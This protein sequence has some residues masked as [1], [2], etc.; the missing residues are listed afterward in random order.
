MFSFT[1]AVCSGVAGEGSLHRGI[2]SKFLDEIG[3]FQFIYGVGMTAPLCDRVCWHSCI[4]EH[5]GGED[6]DDFNGC[7]QPECAESSCYDFLLRECDPVQHAAIT[8]RYKELCTI[9]SCRCTF[10]YSPVCSNFYSRLA[11]G[12]LAGSTESAASAGAAAISTACTALAI[13][14]STATDGAVLRAL[15]RHR[16]RFGCRL[17][18]DRVRPMH[19]SNISVGRVP[20]THRSLLLHFAGT[21]NVPRLCGNLHNATRGI[22][23]IYA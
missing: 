23:A 17:R 15:P 21:P 6:H 8:T 14:K 2:C 4:G 3:K 11:F 10:T 16:D 20:K 18:T 5:L 9:V 12:V 19:Q 22:R 7:R 13:T 1:E